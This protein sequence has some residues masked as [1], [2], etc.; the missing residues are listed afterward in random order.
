[1]NA[2]KLIRR[3]CVCQTIELGGVKI[4]AS[5]YSTGDLLRKGFGFTDSYLSKGCITSQYGD[6]GK[7]LLTK[8]EISVLDERCSL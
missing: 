1:M 3:C 2:K 8:P 6:F 5:Q 4:P 7:E